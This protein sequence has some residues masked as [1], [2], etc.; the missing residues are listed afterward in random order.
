MVTDE[1]MVKVKEVDGALKKKIVKAHMRKKVGYKKLSKRF[2]IPVTNVRGIIKRYKASGTTKS[3]PRSGRPM[4]MTA[5]A[6]R[7]GLIMVK[8]Y[9]RTPTKDPRKAM[10]ESGVD[11][12]D[13]AI[14]RHLHLAGIHGR[15]P[16]RKP[17]LRKCHKQSRLQFTRK[18]IEK[19]NY[20]QWTITKQMG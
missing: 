13:S 6:W 18:L 9:P 17:L 10:E 16:R 5:V 19:D 3:S 7:R 11:V 4:K 12:S 20:F 14:K 8:K 2:D 1:D 15:R